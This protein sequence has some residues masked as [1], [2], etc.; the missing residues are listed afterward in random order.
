MPK[1]PDEAVGV[2]E[3]PLPAGD[4]SPACASAPAAGAEGVSF[5]SPGGGSSRALEE[6]AEA[7]GV[8]LDETVHADPPAVADSTGANTAYMKQRRLENSTSV[9][10]SAGTGSADA[11]ALETAAPIRRSPSPPTPQSAGTDRAP[12]DNHMAADHTQPRQV[13]PL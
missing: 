11:D 9:T 3:A 6:V 13:G 5:G 8:L 12:I 2:V 10:G 1:A 4:L 7:T